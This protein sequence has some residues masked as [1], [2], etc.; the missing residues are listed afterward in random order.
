MTDQPDVW[1]SR[2]TPAIVSVGHK[3]EISGFVEEPASTPR[4]HP[5]VGRR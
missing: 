1:R 5:P 3:V 2:C 4:R